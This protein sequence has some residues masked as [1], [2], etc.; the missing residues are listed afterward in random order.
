MEEEGTT[1]MLDQSFIQTDANINPGNSGGPLV[2][3][4][5]EV[6]GIN[7]LIRGLHTGI[8][9]AIPSNMARGGHADKLIADGK[10]TR[11]WLG[12]EIESLRE[13]PD[14]RELVPGVQDGVVVNEV[15][16]DGPAANSEL[17]PADVITAVDG[18]LV[19]TS[20]QLKQEIRAKPAGVNVTLSSTRQVKDGG[21][22]LKIVVVPA[23]WQ[24]PAATEIAAVT[25]PPASA[26]ADAFGIT[27]SNS[28]HATRG[29]TGVRVTRGGAGQRG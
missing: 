16:A 27:V 19:V 8:G 12:I 6:I 28:R 29:I 25:D 10:F 20:E 23:E 2:N 18:K 3:V 1:G 13:D 5:G 9:Y 21:Q 15:I 11:S 22:R 7:T 4:D 14:F 17:R 24:E 26:P